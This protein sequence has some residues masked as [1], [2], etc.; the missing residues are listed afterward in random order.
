MGLDVNY[1]INLGT[2]CHFPKLRYNE[3]IF[4]KKMEYQYNLS[5]IIMSEAYYVSFTT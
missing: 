3:S 4:P 2:E 5:F 1:F